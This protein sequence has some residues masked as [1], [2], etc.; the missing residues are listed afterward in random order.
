MLINILSL[1]EINILKAGIKEIGYEHNILSF[2][3][4]IYIKQEDKPK[5]PGSLP[6]NKTVYY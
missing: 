2:R 6:I 5:L 3:R 1:S 4:Q